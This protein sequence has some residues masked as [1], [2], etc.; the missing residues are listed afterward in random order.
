MYCYYHQGTYLE[1]MICAENYDIYYSMLLK[2]PKKLKLKTKEE[3]MFGSFKIKRILLDE[4]K[5]I[6]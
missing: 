3:T 4:Y 2:R 6:K 1:P 5:A